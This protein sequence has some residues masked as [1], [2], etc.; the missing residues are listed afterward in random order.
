MGMTTEKKRKK[1]LEIALIGELDDWEHDVI[2]EL[3]GAKPGRQCTFYIDSGG[4]SVYGALAVAT[5]IRQRKLDCT[6]IV[7]GECSSAAILIFAACQKRLVT[8]HSTLLFHRMRWQSDKRVGAREAGNWSKHFE[9]ME[10]EI[11]DLQARLFG[12]ADQQVRA[13]TDTGEYVTGVQIAE[14]GLA[15]LFDV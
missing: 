13:W 15:E 5:L 3:I 8:R 4:G 11:D 14:A 2:K 10:K 1:P 7:L 9:S 12:V 6:G